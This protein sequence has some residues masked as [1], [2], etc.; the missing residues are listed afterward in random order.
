MKG[1]S[2]TT[3]FWELP[4]RAQSLSFFNSQIVTE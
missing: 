2:K 4:G 1:E 3:L